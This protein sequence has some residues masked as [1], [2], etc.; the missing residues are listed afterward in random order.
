LP[1]LKALYR[2]WTPVVVSSEIPRMSAYT[3]NGMPTQRK[4]HNVRAFEVL[5]VLLMDKVGQITSIIEDHVQG[6]SIGK[7]GESLFDA[8]IVFFL[9]FT[10]PGEDR[11]T[12]SGDPESRWV[13]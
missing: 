2:W 7:R 4:R 9:G 5:R 3:V 6:L 13:E 1:S 12:S 8:P 10:F 11:N